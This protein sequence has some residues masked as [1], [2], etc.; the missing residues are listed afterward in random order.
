MEF[1]AFEVVVPVRESIF[2]SEAGDTPHA[3]SHTWAELPI[4]LIEGR[5]N[6]G[7]ITIG[8][9]HRG[10]SRESIETHLRS[11]LH[12]DLSTWH[13]LN[14]DLSLFSEQGMRLLYPIR[15][16]QSPQA[17]FG[18]LNEALWLDALGQ[19]AGVPAH[20]FLGGKVRADVAVDAWANRPNAHQL[21]LLVSE[22]IAHGFTGLKMKCSPSGDTL[23]ALREI[24]AD[25]PPH[26][27][28]TV[29]AM[30]A[31]RT[32]R[33]SARL[34]E[35]VSSLSDRLILEDPFAFAKV[36][37][38]HQC[39]SHL[40]FTLVCHART[41]EHLRHA[42]RYSLADCMNLGG[43]AFEFQYLAQICEFHHLDCWQGSMLE[44]GVGQAL[45]LHASACARSCILPSDLQSA[46]V[47]ESLL[48]TQHWHYE[49]G[50]I[51]VPDLP[52]LGTTL[53]HDEIKRYLTN[54]WSVR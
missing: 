12:Q 4:T 22:A 15:A 17:E 45:R 29:D 47:R 19:A 41:A 49:A 8:E 23:I 51:R 24:A 46:W 16:A 34:L 3:Q 20:A 30:N 43:S 39:R 26:F 33:E 6:S 27:R 28:F 14:M 37:D 52:G 1:S 50:R 5:T 11:L 2:A 18:T 21:S 44:L 32:W 35:S 42:I 53:D 38:W 7:S 31:L 10:L 40:P 48:T 25:V 13:P 9:A 54:E 36:E